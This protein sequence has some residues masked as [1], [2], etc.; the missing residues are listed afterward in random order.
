[1][2]RNRPRQRSV[3]IQSTEVPDSEEDYGFI[4]V[5][6]CK[7][8]AF[9]NLLH[10]S[11]T[12]SPQENN[13]RSEIITLTNGKITRGVQTNQNGLQEHYLDGEPVAE[14]SGLRGSG[15]E[16]VKIIEKPTGNPGSSRITSTIMVS[17]SRYS[18][19]RIFISFSIYNFILRNTIQSK[20]NNKR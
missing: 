19:V 17:P 8:A 6:L 5:K 13:K 1:M 12:V 9:R 11:V 4:S 20:N 3:A 18:E 15:S 7:K 2:Q 10:K 16:M 14:Y